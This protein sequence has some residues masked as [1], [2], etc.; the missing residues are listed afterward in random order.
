[1]FGQYMAVCTY[2]RRNPKNLPWVADIVQRYE[3]LR[4]PDGYV[5]GEE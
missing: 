5:K 1:M 2:Q 4:D 3:Y